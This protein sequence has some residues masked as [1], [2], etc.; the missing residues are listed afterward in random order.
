[1]TDSWHGADL[2]TKRA[3]T[4][5]N[6]EA[7]PTLEARLDLKAR[8]RLE[9]HPNLERR[10]SLER[11][12]NLE[13][14]HFCCQVRHHGIFRAATTPHVQGPIHVDCGVDPSY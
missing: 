7:S 10:P 12:P 3:E 8:P 11:R 5:P 4:S 13:G 14:L 6:L 2:I 1:M 9:A